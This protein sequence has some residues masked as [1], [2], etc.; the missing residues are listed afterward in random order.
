VAFHLGTLASALGD[1]TAAQHHLTVAIAAASDLH[2]PPWE[3][4][5]SVALAGVL[6]R[7]GHSES[8]PRALKL[9]D[10]GLATARRLG[11]AEITGA[12]DSASAR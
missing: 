6:L 8:R 11:L 4:R 3:A 10:D 5:G 2:S 12:G 9:L 7:T 1:F